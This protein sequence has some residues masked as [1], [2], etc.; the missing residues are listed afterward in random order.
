M[1]DFELARALFGRKDGQPRDAITKTTALALSDSADGKVV[2][3]LGGL[4]VTQDGTQGVEID[5]V[6]SVL[7]GQEVSVEIVGGKATV[8]GISGWGDAVAG[9]IVAANAQIQN[10]HASKAD[11]G[12]LEASVARIDD[13]EADFA[14]I[15]VLVAGAATIQQL[16]AATARID[17]LEADTADIGTIRANAAKV[18][19]LTAAQLEADHATV[20]SLDA[21]YAKIGLGNV[22]NAWIGNGT[23][24]NGAITNAM[25]S[26]MSA[27]KLTAGTLDAADINVI[28]LNASNI[29]TGTLN[30]QRIG[31]GSLSLSKLSEDVYTE[32][33]IDAITSD[34]QDQIDGAIET[35]TGADVPTLANPPAN[36]WATDQVRDTH[37]GDVYFVVNPASQQNGYNYRFTKTGSTYSWQLIKDNDVTM[38]LQRLTTAEGKIGTLEQFDADVSSWQVSAE[39][40]MASMQA[41]HTALAGRVGTA[42]GEIAQKVD[43]STFN[44]LSQTV[45][46]NT[47]SITTL[48]SVV[49][50]KA[51][52]STVQTLSNTVNSVQQTATGNSSKLSQLTST[53]GTNPDGTTAADD[54]MHRVSEVEQDLDGFQTTVSSTY[55]T[56]PEAYQAAQPNVSPFFSHDVY[57]VYNATTN[58]DGYWAIITSSHADFLDFYTPIGDGWL[59][60]SHANNKT[61]ARYPAMAAVVD[62]DIVPGEVYT[63]LIE[64]RNLVISGADGFEITP[65]SVSEPS[66]P[67]FLNTAFSGALAQGSYTQVWYRQ[68]TAKT[69]FSGCNTM[70]LGRFKIAVGQ[71]VEGDVRISMYR[72]VYTGPYKPYSDQ[73]LQTRVRTAE[74]T[75]VQQAGLIQTKVSQDG[76][77]SSINQSP[78]SVAIAASRVDVAGAAIFTSGRLSQTSLD[79]AYARRI[80]SFGRQSDTTDKVWYRIAMLER[81]NPNTN[82][83]LRMSVESR[84]GYVVGA[85]GEVMCSIR[86]GPNPISVVA[87]SSQAV[88]LSR[89]VA[90]N[91]APENLALRW[92]NGDGVVQGEVWM[93]VPGTGNWSTMLAEVHANRTNGMTMDVWDIVQPNVGDSYALDPPA[94]VDGWNVIWGTDKDSATAYAGTASEISQRIYHRKASSGA[95]AAPTAWVTSTASSYNAWTTKVPPLAASTAQGASKYPYLYTCEQRRKLNGAVYFTAVLLDDT[96]TVI[97]GGQIVTGSVTANQ[98]AASTLTL[99]KMDTTDPD[100]A[101]GLLNSTV[102]GALQSASQSLAAAIS[103]NESALGTLQETSASQSDAISSLQDIAADAVLRSE[104]R[105]QWLSATAEALT[106]AKSS[107][108]TV[109]QSRFTAEKLG[110]YEGSALLGEYGG[111]DGSRMPRATIEDE[112]TVGDWIFVKRSNGHLSLKAM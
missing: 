2:V 23:I 69:D 40:E 17:T 75:I 5:T 7:A 21:N 20:G 99:G 57:D 89:G 34:L 54:V 39:G 35:W 11:I 51:D 71:T 13:L 36:A 59:H 30:G 64:A 86:S 112:L 97:D 67:Q 27:N 87:S 55:A 88:W 109:L 10:L 108:S 72:G 96:A 63:V 101:A 66:K 105:M 79:D 4:A 38:A 46:T 47:A 83:E 1:D 31:D 32:A 94:A 42:E 29:N 80:F 104:Q 50:G 84:G 98:I 9:D 110:F 14:A 102:E 24:K 68:T 12:D 52:G 61:V 106:I 18:R 65:V 25:I 74:S 92:R 15:D 77:I 3:D 93:K 111:K 91:W 33:E 48:A 16:N 82:F 6:P 45:D 90:I 19:N 62:P 107:G 76:V 73:S 49:D 81:A 78:E 41:A 60:I 103:E 100:T 37:V 70:N 43:T 95:P 8:T 53:L 28:N 56:K 22:N 85:K 58:P 44:Q 26:S